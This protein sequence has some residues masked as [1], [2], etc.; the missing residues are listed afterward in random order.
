MLAPKGFTQHIDK[1]AYI[2]ARMAASKRVGVLRF[3]WVVRVLAI[4]LAAYGVS[5]P[6]TA[7]GSVSVYLTGAAIVLTAAVLILLWECVVVPYQRQSAA[8]D[9]ESFDRISNDATVSFSSDEMT[10]T[11]AVLSRRVEYAKTRVCIEL[12]QRF[13][14]VTD[15]DRAVILEKAAFADGDVTAAFLRDV[16]ARWY[17]RMS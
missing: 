2:A 17:C 5:L 15:D 8:R 4:G 1:D 14:L 6:V 11:S 13:V 7:G 10:L 3:S 12:P 9:F 16:F